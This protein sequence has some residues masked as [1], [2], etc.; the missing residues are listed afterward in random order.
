MARFL[1][2]TDG[3]ATGV[4]GLPHP[5]P[6]RAVD[7]VLAA[8][9]EVPYPP[10]LPNRGPFEQIVWNDARTLPGLRGG[11]GPARGRSRGRPAEAM[12]QIYLD[13]VEQDAAAYGPAP[14]T[15]SGLLDLVSRDLHPQSWSKGQ[16]TGPV[17]FGMQVVDRRQAADPLRRDLR[18][19]PRQDDRAAGPCGRGAAGR[20]GIPETLVVL[21][22]PVL[23]DPW[24]DRG[25]GL[26]GDGPAGIRG[27]RPWSAAGS[28]STAARTPTGPL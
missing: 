20:N 26:G 10:G 2:P 9:P 8:F 27:H 19:Y 4:G 18:G 24:F 28:G 23:G 7:D 11:R 15:C 17:T 3:R 1:T 6:A 5:D 14:E 16:V 13:F 12:E 22:E 25:P 21:N